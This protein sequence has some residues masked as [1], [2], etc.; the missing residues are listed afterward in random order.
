MVVGLSM[1]AGAF[2]AFAAIGAGLALF[3][4]AMVAYLPYLNGVLAG[5]GSGC[6]GRSGLTVA[7]RPQPLGKRPS[8]QRTR[9][10]RPGQ[11]PS[12]DQAKP[13]RPYP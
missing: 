11:V 1:G 12:T 13:S 6:L 8:Q 7:S 2:S 9:S 5:C 3:G 10:V 4:A